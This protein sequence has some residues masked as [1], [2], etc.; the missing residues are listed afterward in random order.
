MAVPFCLQLFDLDYKQ[1][2]A[3][4][5]KPEVETIP[6]SLLVFFKMEEP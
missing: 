3:Q 4:L 2:A 1:T 6:S 5:A